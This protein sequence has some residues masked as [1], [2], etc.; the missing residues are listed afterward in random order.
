LRD[1]SFLSHD[2][3]LVG[4]CLISVLLTSIASTGQAFSQAP[5][6]IQYFS[7]DLTFSSISPDAL[8]LGMKVHY[9][10]KRQYMLHR[11]GMSPDL[12][13][14]HLQM[15][16]NLSCVYWADFL[17]PSAIYTGFFIYE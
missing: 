9:M 11:F 13:V 6:Y 8:D 15:L 16:F 7:S 4:V 2:F 17:T 5:Q 3:D 14:I 1:S 12:L 10:G